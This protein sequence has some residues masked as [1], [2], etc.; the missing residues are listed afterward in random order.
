[1]LKNDYFLLY[2]SMEEIIMNKKCIIC[3]QENQEYYKENDLACKKCRTRISIFK[4]IRK[5]LE[6]IESFGGKCSICG[7]E[8]YYGALH[9]HH[10]NPSNKT[11]K[12]G[13][14]ISLFL[15]ELKDCILI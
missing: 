5:K 11:T 14:H 2:Y 10:T 6:A 7:Y 8:K 9:F 3:D 1:M 4:D 15:E 12:R 13:Q